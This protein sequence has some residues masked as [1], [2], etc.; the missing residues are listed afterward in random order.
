MDGPAVR[1]KLP[2]PVLLLTIV[3][4]G[5]VGLLLASA[6]AGLFLG[7]VRLAIIL[8]GFVAIGFVGLFLWRR[9]EISR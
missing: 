9:G 1:T 6:A 4:L 7:I 5:V 8:A 2:I 3:A